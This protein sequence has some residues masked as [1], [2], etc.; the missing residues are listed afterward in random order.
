VRCAAHVDIVDA[1]SWVPPEGAMFASHEEAMAHFLA[2]FG[3][4]LDAMQDL[5]RDDVED[6]RD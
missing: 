1:M 3:D 2:D 4:G 6:K 5:A